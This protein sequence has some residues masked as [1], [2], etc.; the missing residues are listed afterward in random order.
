M[1]T[2][3][4]QQISLATLIIAAAQTNGTASFYRLKVEIPKKIMLTASDWAPSTTRNG[5]P[6]WHQLIRNIKSHSVNDGNFIA[7]GWLE[8]V[9]RVGYRITAAGRRYLA[10]RK[11]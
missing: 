4:E 2:T 5:E 11:P 9:P 1:T 10:A 8:H 7:E 6:M 3:N